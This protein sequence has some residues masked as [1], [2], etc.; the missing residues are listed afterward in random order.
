M[1]DEL[2]ILKFFY[3]NYKGDAGYRTIKGVPVFWYGETE[4]HK[5]RQWLIKA[6]DVDKD[7]VR[8]F[9]LKD[10]IEFV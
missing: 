10:I 2:P 6:Y 7:A 3:R 5:G 9:A 1:N 4:F 8:D